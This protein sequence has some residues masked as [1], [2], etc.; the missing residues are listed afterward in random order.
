MKFNKILILITAI[1]LLSWLLP[2]GY[3]F[4][5]SKP[6]N[7]PF[8]LY[9]CITHNFAYADRSSGENVYRDNQGNTYTNAQFDSILPTFYYRQLIAD[10]RLPAE[11]E[12]VPVDARSIQRGGFMFRHTP[13]N[14]NVIKAPLYFLLESMSGRVDLTMPE[15]VFRMTDRMEFVDMATN[16]VNEEK[17]RQFTKALEDKGFTFPARFIA[18][19][20]TVRK[21]YDEGFLIIDRNHQVFHVKQLRGR[22]F[23]RNTGIAPAMKMKHASVTEFRNR[24]FHGILT[25][26]ANQVY[27]L[28]TKTYELKK[29]AIPSFDPE[30]ESIN[31]FGDDFYWTVQ[32]SDDRNVRLYAIKSGDYSLVDSLAYSSG[33]D[34]ADRMSQYIFPFELSFTSYADKFVY[35]RLTNPSLW[36]I[37]LNLLLLAVYLISTRKHIASSWPGSIVILFFGIFALLPQ[38]LL[39][40]KSGNL[41]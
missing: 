11:I 7:V 17:S 19:N 22:P 4:I 1:A 28:E 20:Q 10:N 21:D 38:I 40:G 33:E 27:V 16:T 13:V 15:D 25:D 3:H 30:K 14:I 18:G 32:I 12:D 36:A 37:F 2:W 9:S 24:R 34:M 41:R 35:P 8:T 31:I 6:A 5:A 26:E 29:L 39:A 23:V